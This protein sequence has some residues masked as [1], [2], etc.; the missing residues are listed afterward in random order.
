MDLVDAL[1]RS[2][3]DVIATGLNLDFEGRPYG[4]ASRL[5]TIADDLILKKAFCA[6]DGCS[7]PASRSKKNGELYVPA[8]TTHF[9]SWKRPGQDVSGS[10]VLECGSM[11]SGKSSASEID[12]EET[13]Q[14]G[15]DCVS[16]KWINDS[17]GDEGQTIEPF[18]ECYVDLKDGK[19]RRSIAIRDGKDIAE[20]L[21]AHPEIRDIIIDEVEFVP[22]AYDTI[23][24]L[25][26]QGYRIRGTGLPRTFRRRDFGELP[27]LMCLADTVNTHIA[28]CQV[29]Y[30]PATDNQRLR[31]DSKKFVPAEYNEDTIAVDNKESKAVYKY[32]PRCIQHIAMPGEPPL[33]FSF[34]LYMKSV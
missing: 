31:F 27:A 9:N 4:T 5:M 25:L 2:N 10:L 12:F 30:H 33:K 14:K 26:P 17:R 19:K 28:Y 22:D 24:R 6:K 29:C 20:Y 23:F 16:F 8:C 7:S 21:T 32:E 11:R 18:G 15:L 13:V 3:R 34:P 1:V